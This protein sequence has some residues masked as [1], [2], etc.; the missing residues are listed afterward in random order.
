MVLLFSGPCLS[1]ILCL[2]ALWPLSGSMVP[3][4]LWFSCSLALWFTCFLVHLLSGFL[5]QTFP[6]SMVPWLYGSMV[7][8]FNG[9]VQ[10]FN[11]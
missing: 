11:G 7:I 5:V 9:I 8:W 1:I 4:V 3:L 6:N 2:R 10:W